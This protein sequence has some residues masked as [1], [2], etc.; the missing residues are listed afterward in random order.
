M[1]YAV[2]DNPVKFGVII[3]MKQLAVAPDRVKTDKNITGDNVAFGIIKRYNVGI[4]VV[5][6]ILPVDFQYLPV[7]TEDIRY[8]A[9]PFSV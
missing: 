2:G 3:G 6:E 1:Q 5:T 8:V 4:V 7:I 9:Y